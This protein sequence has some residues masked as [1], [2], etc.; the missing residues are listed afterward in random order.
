M[1]K[2]K[3][4]IT[5]MLVICMV[6]AT[7]S[8]AFGGNIFSEVTR[9][10]EIKVSK[11]AFVSSRGCDMIDDV[12]TIN[13][14]PKHITY[15]SGLI[16]FELDDLSQIH[17]SILES[18][19]FDIQLD[20][21]L[22]KDFFINEVS[23]W[24]NPGKWLDQH[25]FWLVSPFKLNVKGFQCE[26]W[27]ESFSAEQIAANE[28][29][30]YGSIGSTIGEGDVHY[31]IKT[32]SKTNSQ[33]ELGTEK[34]EG[35]ISY[36]FGTYAGDN[37][38]PKTIAEK[39][40]NEGKIT[41]LFDSSKNETYD[42]LFPK[43]EIYGSCGIDIRP[44]QDGSATTCLKIWWDQPLV[45]GTGTKED[46]YWI[47]SK[48]ALEWVR[49]KINKG[50]AAFVNAHYTQ[51]ADIDL[52]GD[53][54]TPIKNFSGVYDGNG[55]KITNMKIKSSDNQKGFFG[56]LS[57][58]TIMNLGIDN[59]TFEGKKSSAHEGGLAGYAVDSRILNCYANGAVNTQ[60][61]KNDQS[62][63]GGLVGCVQNTEVLACYSAGTVS[64]GFAAGL[65]G[66]VEGERSYVQDCYSVA[67]V[68]Y[69]KEYGAGLAH[70]FGGTVE[71]CY[72]L[73]SDSMPAVW[74]LGGRATCL[75]KTDA[76]MSGSKLVD[77]LYKDLY[78]VERKIT[79]WGYYDKLSD[80]KQGEGDYPYP[81]LTYEFPEDWE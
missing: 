57:G 7:M 37:I 35:F 68:D 39:W 23:F 58:A 15:G 30:Q 24:E 54:W 53:V 42:R 56:F 55:H 25:M 69:S 18:G 34:R 73:F 52:E 76:F 47:D 36:D 3:R 2:R 77:A 62:N 64:G 80:W 20:L 51:A 46:P 14:D 19:D 61:E 49:N 66:R 60:S 45:P 4:W 74:E 26:S 13:S 28:G 65:I 70:V 38:P 32:N 17:P 50:D 72:S 71:N 5:F 6:L 33:N 16:Q 9:Q 11:A 59:F 67:K 43:A 31:Y 27:D 12:L 63:A 78:K 8:P 81:V 41:F 79:Q 75:S 29:E 10:I 44:W 40:K 22:K 21:S 48:E 1:N